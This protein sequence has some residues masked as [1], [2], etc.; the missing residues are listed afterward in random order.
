MRTQ[1]NSYDIMNEHIDINMISG[2]N[3]QGQTNLPIQKVAMLATWDI[4]SQIKILNKIQISQNYLI[5][6]LYNSL[7][8][9]QLFLNYIFAWVLY[10]LY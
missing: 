10:V 9:L 6:Q 2:Q 8:A 4:K 3:F 7:I 1:S 5:Q